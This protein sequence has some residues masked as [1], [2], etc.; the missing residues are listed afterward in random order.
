MELDIGLPVHKLED[1]IVRSFGG[2]KGPLEERVEAMNRR[3]QRFEC[4]VRV[5]PLTARSG[6]IY[7]SM[8]LASP[9]GGD[10]KPTTAG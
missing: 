3:G 7:A 8:I 2:A 10:K 5:M 6:E 1:A 9:L 4:L